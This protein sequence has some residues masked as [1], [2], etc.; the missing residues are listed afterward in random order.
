[1]QRRLK[2]R[3]ADASAPAGPEC[4]R[5][6]GH[7]LVQLESPAGGVFLQL[8]D[9]RELI[10]APRAVE[11]RHSGWGVASEQVIEHGP[12]RG[13]PC[14]AGN[15]QYAVIRRD[16]RQRERAD[17]S[18]DVDQGARACGCEVGARIAAGVDRDKQLEVVCFRSTFRGTGDGIGPSIVLS[19][20][21]NN[22]RLAG[23]K[24]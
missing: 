9:E 6:A 2:V 7:R 19:L 12:Q 24:V 20:G 1:M 16:F 3:S 17:R 14:P 18:F 11:Q 4:A 15:T 22:D 10:A 8:I 5:V 21:A 23:K 13:D